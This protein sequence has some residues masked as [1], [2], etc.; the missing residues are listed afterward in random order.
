MKV[1]VKAMALPRRQALIHLSYHAKEIEEHIVKII[2]YGNYRRTAYS[3]WLQEL[4]AWFAY[5]D[6]NNITRLRLREQDY[7]ES[8]FA[9]FCEDAEDAASALF[10]F[11]VD[12]LMKHERRNKSTVLPYFYINDEM[13]TKLYDCMHEIKF[14]S[15][16]DLMNPVYHATSYWRTKLHTILKK[17]MYTLENSDIADNIEQVK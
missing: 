11:Q 8:M 3:H 4:A 16:E 2:M 13:S 10:Q 12:N 17:H 1:Y 15:L 5:C 14:S 9:Y 6:E 7:S